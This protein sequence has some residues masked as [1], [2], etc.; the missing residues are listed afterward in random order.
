MFEESG[1][2]VGMSTWDLSSDVFAGLEA[3]PAPENNNSAGDDGAARAAP[4]FV[5]QTHAKR[6][7]AFVE[8]MKETLKR[9]CIAKIKAHYQSATHRRRK[10]AGGGAPAAI[11]AQSQRD[12]FESTVAQEIDN[13]R[14]DLDRVKQRAGST[15]I[16]SGHQSHHRQ[17]QNPES[18]AA[19]G[20]WEQKTLNVDDAGGLSE[21]EPGD[22]VV[23]SDDDDESLRP[24]PQTY[25]DPEQLDEETYVEIMQFL[26]ENVLKEL[27]RQEM[28]LVS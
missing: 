26:E 25:E 18:L 10:H 9:T 24:Q 3:S 1:S 6:K 27:E 21:E 2:V 4:P 14:R 16:S 8:R 12:M 19:A 17:T 23:E 13:C 11:D 20:V 28:N 15:Q 22:K 7:R 5:S